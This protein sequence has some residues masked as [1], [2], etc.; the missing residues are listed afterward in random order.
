MEHVFTLTSA[1]GTSHT[2]MMQPHRGSEGAPLAV[3]LSA[4]VVDPLVTGLGSIL[5]EGLAGGFSPSQMVIDADTVARLNMAQISAGVRGALLGIKPDLMCAVLKYTN[6]DGKPLVSPE[7][8]PTMAYDGAYSC[9]YLEL[10]RALWEV[11][12]FNGFFPGLSTA[13]SAAAKVSAATQ[14]P[15]ESGD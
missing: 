3:R 12:R 9:N 14:E 13:I 4:L 7:G 15:P 5:L 1:Q 10:A 8:K 6:R 11:A 2:Y